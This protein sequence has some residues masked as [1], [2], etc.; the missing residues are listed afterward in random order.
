MLTR[1][2]RLRRQERL[3]ESI[4]CG[5]SLFGSRDRQQHFIGLL[6]YLEP[7]ER[8]ALPYLLHHVPHA[9]RRLRPIPKSQCEIGASHAPVGPGAATDC[10]SRPE[11]ADSTVIHSDPALERRDSVMQADRPPC[12]IRGVPRRSSPNPE[13]SAGTD[14]GFVEAC[15]F[16]R[17]IWR[18]GCTSWP[19]C[20][21]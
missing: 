3:K 13:L 2:W 11:S 12:A 7:Q 6:M 18:T 15:S 5:A 17:G 16:V 20:G 8:T 19:C 9:L 1:W 21:C 4:N 10:T 14:Y